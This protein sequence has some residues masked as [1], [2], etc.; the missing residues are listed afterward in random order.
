MVGVEI[1]TRGELRAVWPKPCAAGSHPMMESTS[2]LDDELNHLTYCGKASAK[3]IQ[4]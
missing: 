3:V 4:G 1:S 2:S